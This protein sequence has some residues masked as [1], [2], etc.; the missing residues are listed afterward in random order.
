MS[1]SLD[2]L[3][4]AAGHLTFDFDKGDPAEVERAK[5]VVEDMLRR[6]Y[7]IFVETPEGLAKVEAF[8][9][10]TAHYVISDV[11]AARGKRGPK[12]RVPMTGSRATA[13]APT[14]GG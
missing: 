12:K 4:C 14:G 10:G 5:R 9:P 8:D 11:P 2:V 13:T 7:T 6:G 1:G 3:N